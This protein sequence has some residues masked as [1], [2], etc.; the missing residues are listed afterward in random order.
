MAAQL[1]LKEVAVIGGGIMG[2]GIAALFANTNIRAKV[3][4]V[5]LELARGAIDK[6]ADPKAKI[7]LLYSTKYAER[8][9]PFSVDDYAKQLGSADL[10]VEVVPEVMSLKQKV[11]QQIDQHRRKGSIVATNTSG[12]SVNEMVKGCSDDM[13]RHFVGTH[14]F[15]PVRFL[16]LV[17]LIPTAQAS[18]E[19]I[20][21]LRDFFVGVGKKPIIG[22]DTPNFVANRVGIFMMMQ[23]LKLQEKYGFTV[24]EVDMITGSPLGNPNTATFRLSDM[25]GIDTLVHAAQNSFENCPQD[26]SR[27]VQEP[28]AFLKKMVEMGLLGD[29]TGKGFYQRTKDKKFLVLDLHTL[30]YRPKTEPRADCVRVA[31]NFATAP[32]RILSMIR[33]GAE[34]KVSRFSRELVLASAAY[35]L[36]RVG[37]IADDIPTIDN[38]M[39]WGFAKEVGPIEILDHIGTERAARMMQELGIPVPRLL[40]QIID[41]GGRCYQP[42][43]DGSTAYFDIASK[44]VKREPPPAGVINLGV[45]KEGGKIVRENL[46]ARLL[47]LGDGVLCCELDAKMVPTM[48]PVDDYIISMLQQAK[49]L[50]E[51]RGE[52]R[53]LVIGNQAANF[54]AGA[55]LQL[56]LELS[57]QKRWKE[58]ET[59]TR[60]LQEINLGLYHASFPVVTAPHGMT[61]GGGLEVTFAGQKRVPYAELY[62]G[63]VEV[64][65]GLIPAGGGCTQLVAQFARVMAPGQPGPVPPVM[66]AFE[67]IG[68]GKVSSS[69]DDAI[70]K[71]LLAADNTIIAYNKDR[72]IAQAKQ[73]ALDM[74]AGFKPIPRAELVLPGPGGYYVME[75]SIEGFKVAGTITEHS[76]KIAKIHARVLTGGENASPVRPLSE[77]QMLE[78]EREA[79]LK[80]CGEPM[81]QERMAH[82]LKTGKPLI[83]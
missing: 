41:H 55:Q 32:G 24:E 47:D 49:R 21:Q 48:N 44:A 1:Q 29:K 18:P 61:L 37:E 7:P 64:G 76:A 46:N 14:Y 66:K 5:K 11:F 3:F 69:A 65:V 62:C 19:L 15:N 23:T 56:V 20:A 77:E 67:L 71:G 72:Q 74:L 16:P 59:V 45:L 51:E 2:A 63:L 6:L 38:A 30:E 78:L 58:L 43:A 57:R 40:E 39:K 17:E 27:A 12:L 80:L 36:N 25:V 33:Y 73:V 81:S 9:V 54:C 70:D 83:N 35:A 50:I 4:D 52:F 13:K 42:T 10:I 79:F 75:E 60:D 31:K 82:M 68:F 28:P 53:A 8:I 22:K 34:D 26:E